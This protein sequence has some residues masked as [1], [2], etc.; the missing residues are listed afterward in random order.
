MIY[1]LL[2]VAHI[3]SATLFLGAGLASVFYKLAAD[4]SGQ[5]QAIAF[6][7]Q[8]VIRADWI[9]TIPSGVL[10]PLTGLGMA[11]TAGLPLSTPWI[12]AGIVLYTVAGISW[13]PAFFLQYR[14]ASLAK[15]AADTGQPLPP[16]Y[17]RATRIWAMLGVPAFFA[18][19]AAI[20]I[21]TG[22][23]MVLG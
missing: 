2:K 19:V 14:M 5:P 8:G 21:M 13:L 10:L 11:H 18:A 1:V 3:L 23:G 6:V 9:F 17:H 12:T 22:K 15:I 4:H 7:L 16:A 20:L